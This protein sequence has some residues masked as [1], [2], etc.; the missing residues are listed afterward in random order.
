MGITGHLLRFI[1]AFLSDRSMQ[2]KLGTVLSRSRKITRG[3]PQGSVLSPMLFNVAM[4]GLPNALETVS[5]AVQIS[6]YAD[7][8]CIWLSG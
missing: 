8:I 3:V 6:I 2:V 5:K 4:A 7:D 1:Q